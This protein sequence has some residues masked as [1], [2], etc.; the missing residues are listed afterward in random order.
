[1]AALSTAER[2]AITAQITTKLEQLDN[3]N[4]TMRRLL[5]QEV[6]DYRFDTSEGSQRAKRVKVTELQQVIEAL[7]SQIDNL[8]RKLHSGGLRT[9]NLRRKGRY[10]G[11]GI[12]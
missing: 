12:G 7:E 2:S 10:T 4:D 11:Y 9:L 1:M 5:K 6:E 3:A 8:Y